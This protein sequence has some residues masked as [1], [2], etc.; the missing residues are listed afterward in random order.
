MPLSERAKKT[1]A[2]IRTCMFWTALI[3]ILTIVVVTLLFPYDRVVQQSIANAAAQMGVDIHIDNL[4]YKFPN[5]II[6]NGVTITPRGTSSLVGQTH[7]ENIDCTM[8]L[9]P[10]MDKQ[11]DIQRFQGTLNPQNTEEGNYIIEGAFLILPGTNSAGSRQTLNIKSLNVH[12]QKVN[13][14]VRGNV[15][16]T[17]SLNSTALDLSADIKRLDRATSAD[18]SLSTMFT[19]MKFAMAKDGS[20]P[21][22]RLKFTGVGTNVTVDRLPSD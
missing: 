2:T 14:N 17:G 12:G 11:I 1:I 15:T 3:L 21:P 8:S 19:A 4:D 16:T 5:R 13:L 20:E 18:K 9:K 22:V 7:W 6:C 10:L